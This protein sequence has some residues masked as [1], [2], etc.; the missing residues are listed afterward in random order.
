[1][2]HLQNHVAH[3]QAES[4]PRHGVGENNRKE[5]KGRYR[6]GAVIVVVQSVRE[7]QCRGHTNV[8]TKDHL[9]QECVSIALDGKKEQ[10]SHDLRTRIQQSQHPI[11]GIVTP[12]VSQQLIDKGLLEIPQEC[13]LSLHKHFHS[14]PIPKIRMRR[15]IRQGLTKTE[16]AAAV[17]GVKALLLG[18]YI[19]DC[20][21]GAFVTGLVVHLGVPRRR[22]GSTQK[23]GKE[24]SQAFGC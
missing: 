20:F 10:Q 1:M 18:I 17:F 23:R 4:C 12:V 15:K 11:G 2:L 9:V 5:Q 16:F 21:G 3:G 7:Q 19:D 13:V 8:G 24:P 6:Q 22:I 14:D